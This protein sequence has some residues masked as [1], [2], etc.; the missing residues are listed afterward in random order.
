LLLTSTPRSNRQTTVSARLVT[1]TLAGFL[2]ACAA[3]PAQANEPRLDAEIPRL[4]APH[5]MST[6]TDGLGSSAELL[7]RGVGY[8]NRNGSR[9]VRALQVGLTRLGYEP[10][11]I[12]G[13]Y[14]VRTEAAVQRFQRARGLAADG[15]VG[16]QTRGRLRAQRAQRLAAPEATPAKGSH[17]GK[18]RSPATPDRATSPGPSAEPDS[19][20]GGS[21]AYLALL[22]AI[23]AGLVGVAL[24]AVRRRHRARPRPSPPPTKQVGTA[25]NLGLASAVLL[26]VFAVGAAGGAVFASQSAPSSRAETA[27]GVA[28]I[29][30]AQVLERPRPT[31]AA[32]TRR[33]A[34]LKRTAGE[35]RGRADLKRTASAVYTVRDGDSLWAI[36]D[37]QLAQRASNREV[38]VRVARLAALN[39]D[40]RIASGDP[41][42]IMP[43]EELML[44]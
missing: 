28:R 6:R 2:C 7:R 15:V 44:R 11:P 4:E 39:L 42:L 1:V 17:D 26:G 32:Q 5:A 18:R 12:D 33:P 8:E 35:T 43:G 41:D 19:S 37:R 27:T 23:A 36:A 16:P 9:A 10:G 40:D 31:G 14:G 29:R 38:T 21:P 20:A 13:L 22:G 34:T 25:R 30:G 24:W 3:L